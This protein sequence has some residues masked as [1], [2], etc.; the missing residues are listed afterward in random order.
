MSTIGNICYPV[1]ALGLNMV[2]ISKTFVCLIMIPRLRI[3]M[4]GRYQDEF[5]KRAA[6]KP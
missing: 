6:L 1:R 5:S 4:F 2:G 3:H